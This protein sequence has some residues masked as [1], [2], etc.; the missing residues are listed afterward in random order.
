MRQRETHQIPENESA[1]KV[2]KKSWLDKNVDPD[3]IVDK[4]MNKNVG[5]AQ[6]PFRPMSSSNS[7]RLKQT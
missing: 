5:N 3:D 2:S 1:K 7:N 4:L 6:F